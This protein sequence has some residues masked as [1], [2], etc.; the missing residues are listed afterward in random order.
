MV[1]EIRK[2][3]WNSWDEV[4]GIFEVFKLILER[5]YCEV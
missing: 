4:S 2:D 5:R 1:N 3:R